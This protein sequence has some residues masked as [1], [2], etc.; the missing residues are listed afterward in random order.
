MLNN[1]TIQAK[2]LSALALII[3]IVLISSIF[4]ILSLR[5]A[6]IVVKELNQV[7]AIKNSVTEAEKE[8]IESHEALVTFL[9]T[10]DLEQ[11]AVYEEGAQQ[12]TGHFER[13]KEKVTDQALIDEIVQV[14]N[15][16][17]HWQNSIA[18]EQIKLMRSP[19][20]VDMA[21]LMESS[22]ENREIW[23][24]FKTEFSLIRVTLSDLEAAK[25]T[26]LQHTMHN[27]NITSIA[28]ALLI[29]V[30]TFVASA[31]IVFFVSKPLKKL[32]NVTNALVEKDWSIE[33]NN[34]KNNDEIG[35]MTNAL[36]LFR[37]NGIENEELIKAQQIE[38]EKKL[39]RASE[40][41]QIV[42]KFRQDSSAVTIALK[43]AT[44]K[45]SASS[46]T[47]SE[48]A[49]D[50]TTLSEEVSLSAQSAGVNVNNVSAATEELTAS[51]QE[52]SRQ[53]T[54]TNKMAIEAKDISSSTVE[55]IRV[56]E[57]SANE[58]GSVIEIISDIAE[59]TNL[60]ALN[61]TIEAARA[62]DAG[63][64]FAVVASEV[65]TL[66]NETA[67]ATEQVQ[68]QI[69]R[70]QG[71]T[72]EVVESIERIS[73]SIEL[74]TENITAISAAIE[75]QTSATQEISRN[76]SEASDSTSTVVQ[77]IS[78]VS[79]ATRR[80]QE[81]SQGVSDLAQELDERSDHLKD[82]IATFIENVQ[83]A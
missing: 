49:N 29:L 67:K 79:E 10:G 1:I 8:I 14:E 42:E 71:D 24:E 70:I 58:I 78:N 77:N 19:Y 55:K 48:T 11:K 34:T 32:V 74:L 38:D 6:S 37:D 2:L 47:M 72:S 68:Q 45:M 75:E 61:A 69:D 66:A 56:L 81:T 25:A 80:T 16:L 26:L 65:K 73:K 82:S 40:I 46:V 13:I 41:E 64:G 23:K 12:I 53:L 52:I 22:E 50:T 35:Q 21:R 43:D 83:K 57:N 31:F 3:T 27:T 5:N 76:V 20:T 63:K 60:L 4:N 9:N 33:I 54:G 62:G 7:S 18:S 39:A 36:V 17:S 59:Q 51:I 15:S 28:G 30:T 44:K